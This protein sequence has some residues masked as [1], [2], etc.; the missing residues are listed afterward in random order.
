MRL[1]H[2]QDLGSS[3]VGVWLCL[4]PLVLG[5]IGI[6]AWTTAVLGVLVILFAIEGLTMPSYFEEL[7]EVIMGV[8]LILAP[9]SLSYDSS[10]AII[11]S[12]VSGTLIAAF[13]VSEMFTD[14]EFTTWCRERRPR[15]FA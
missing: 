9:W 8:A 7:F 5:V 4:S 2:W 6:S 1:I 12:I 3:A 15:M 14:Q 13:A 10:G 11:N